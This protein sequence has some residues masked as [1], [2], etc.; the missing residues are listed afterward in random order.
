MGSAHP[1]QT[2]ASRRAKLEEARRREEAHR[3]R[4]RVLTIV[5]SIA[6][7]AALAGGGAYLIAHAEDQKGPGPAL[8]GERTWSDLG[9]DHVR[10]AVDYPMNPPVGGDHSLVWMNCDA[11]VYTKEIPDMNA[12]HSLEH[13][14]VWVT[15]NDRA[16]AGD[17][18]KLRA[19]VSATSYSLM[20]PVKDQK[21]PLMLTAWGRQLV[22]PNASDPRV[23]KFFDRYV[24]GRQTPEPG[25]PCSGGLS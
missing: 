3:R 12:V 16:A 11:Q 13:G 4:E 2:G 1:K 6:A 22:V 23:E 21:A 9:R 24:Q 10:T 17:L 14:A 25:A 20:S 18:A 5:A 7:V 15:Y 8:A 19:R